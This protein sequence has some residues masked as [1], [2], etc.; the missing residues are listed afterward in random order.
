MPTWS[1][2]S[3]HL[4]TCWP[5]QS[6]CVLTGQATNGDHWTGG[7]GGGSSLFCYCPASLCCLQDLWPNPAPAAW[8]DPGEK[9]SR[10][11]GPPS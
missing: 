1:C 10:C 7:A 2:I 5:S 11:L 4:A 6:E 3:T 9:A 8:L